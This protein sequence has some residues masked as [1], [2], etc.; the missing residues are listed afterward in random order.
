MSR[1]PVCVIGV[2]PA[3]RNYLRELRTVWDV[4]VVGLVNR[5]VERREAVS[6]ET[7]VP[8]FASLKD[9]LAGVSVRPRL[10]VIAT[11]NTTHK[12]LAIEAM[13]AGLD[14]FCEKPMA[15]TLDDCRLMLDAERRTGRRLQIGLEYR[16]GSMTSRVKALQ[17]EGFFGTVRSV[18][19]IDSRGHWW[20]ER[21]DTPVEE[22][23]RLNRATGGGPVLHCGIHQLDLLRHYAGEVAEVQAFCPPQSLAFYPA[24]IPDHFTLHLRFRGGAAGSLTVYHNIGPTWYRP[25]P[26]WVP[27]Y[28]EVPGHFMDLRLTGSG[29]AAVAELYSEQL[30][31]ARYDIEHRETVYERSE[32]FG[33]HHPNRSHHD[34]T[35]MIVRLCRSLAQG[36]GVLHSAEDSYRTTVLGMVCEE[37]VQEALSSGWTSQR[38]SVPG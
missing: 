13:E 36:G 23:W 15:M 5:G 14:C 34:T 33:H 25:I 27:R 19:A 26:P 12:D 18:D 1:F 21:P 29:G 22:V 38:R 9:L 37:A 20:P 8:G 2:G 16:Y 31:L 10:A 17:D 32:S 28:H 11:A 7:G 30:H 6:R 3:G 4:E 35:G 24:D